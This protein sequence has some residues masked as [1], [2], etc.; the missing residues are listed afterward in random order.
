MIHGK[1]IRDWLTNEDLFREEI[2][3]NNSI[4]HY[5]VEYPEGNSIDIIQ[6]KDKDDLIIIGCATNISPEHTNFLQSSSIE[7]NRKLIW[8]FKFTINQML[9]DFQ[10]DHPNNVIKTFIISDEL[11]EEE[12]NRHKLVFKG[13]L[14]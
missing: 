7:I 1:Q 10:I 6:P 5:I 13:D 3:D 8:D 14:P 4:F 12:V 11:Y 9:L 2:H